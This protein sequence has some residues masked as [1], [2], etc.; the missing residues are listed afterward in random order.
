MKVNNKKVLDYVYVTNVIPK[1]ICKE[2]IDSIDKRDWEKHKWYDYGANTM[3]SEDSKE[4]DVQA[5]T[6][7][8]QQSM[9]P[10]LVK[11]YQEYNN[12][13]ADT[14]N[15]R[16]AQLATKFSPI[17]FNRYEKGTMMR[18]H[19]DHIHSLFDG[20][21]KGIPVLSF[22]GCLNEG[23]KGGDFIICEKKLKLKAGDIIIFPSCFMFPHAVTELKKGTR[24]SFVSWAF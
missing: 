3:K 19:Y 11:A 21:H 16:L 20:Q 4:L 7:E 12:K 17:R 23:F 14:R 2:I 8:M 13:F 6:A 9:T 18:M 1:N 10:I 15:T 5:I 24:Y 22:V